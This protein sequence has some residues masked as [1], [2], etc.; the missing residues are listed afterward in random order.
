MKQM[1]VEDYI[2]YGAGYASA[3]LALHAIIMEVV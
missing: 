2:A 3:T 1:P